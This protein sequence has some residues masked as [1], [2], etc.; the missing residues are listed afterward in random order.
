MPFTELKN[1]NP[2]IGIFFCFCFFSFSFLFASHAVCN[3]HY[4]FTK[5]FIHLA[6]INIQWLYSLN[7]AFTSLYSTVLWWEEECMVKFSLS[8]M[9]QAIFS[10][11]RQHLFVKKKKKVL[12]ILASLWGQN[13]K[14]WFSVFPCIFQYCPVHKAICAK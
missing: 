4:A 9:A 5:V 6:N 12:L 8:L 13:W 2:N 3:D 1:V 7:W 11:L 10:D 14:S